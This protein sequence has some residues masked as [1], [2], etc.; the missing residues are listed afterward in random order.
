[1][2]MTGVH[3]SVGARISIQARALTEEN[4][5]LLR[6]HGQIATSRISLYWVP[7]RCRN[8]RIVD[9][10]RTTEDLVGGVCGEGEEEDDHQDHDR[11]DIV[12]QERGFD[13]AEHGV[14][15]DTNGKQE[16]SCCGRNAGE[17]C[18]YRSAS[19]EQH[20]CD[21]DVGHQTEDDVYAVRCGSIACSNG[22]EEGVCIGS[23]A[24]QLNGQS[25]EE[26]DLHGCARSVPEGT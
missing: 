2:L 15:H 5:A 7:L 22:F 13:A 1:M 11:V 10:T 14:Q 19:C 21:E 18:D 20:G 23:F 25:G 12:C 8:K 3:V 4:R 16:T 9:L 17:R 6:A 24:L 26:D